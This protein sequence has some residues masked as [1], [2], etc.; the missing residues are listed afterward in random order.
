MYSSLC[1][2]SGID[3]IDYIAGCSRFKND[4]VKELVILMLTIGDNE[5]GGYAPVAAR[6]CASNASKEKS[7]W[8]R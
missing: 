1:S 7:R 6:F 8:W 5:G 4:E 3:V 2:N